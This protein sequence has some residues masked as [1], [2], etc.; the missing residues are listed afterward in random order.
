MADSATGRTCV[1]TGTALASAMQRLQD[2]RGRR[3]SCEGV[4]N[5]VEITGDSEDKVTSHSKSV[6]RG[7]GTTATGRATVPLLA[8]PLGSRSAAVTVNGVT[9]PW[10]IDTGSEITTLHESTPMKIGVKF[11]KH[12]RRR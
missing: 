1:A 9:L 2:T 3:A 10:I 6:R 4:Q 5:A 11:V 7:T 12:C 8:N